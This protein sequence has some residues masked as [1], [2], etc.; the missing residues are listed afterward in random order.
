MRKLENILGTFPLRRSPKAIYFFS[1]RKKKLLDT[2]HSQACVWPIGRPFCPPTTVLSLGGYLAPR[3]GHSRASSHFNQGQ[4][5]Y[6][7]DL[8]LL[9]F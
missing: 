1:G 4:T 6:C 3:G 8:D 5:G 7:L 2:K 9:D